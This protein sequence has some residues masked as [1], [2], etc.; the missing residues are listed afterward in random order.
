M[1][2]RPVPWN[3]LFLGL[4]GRLDMASLIFVEFTKKDADSLLFFC[5][6]Y[7]IPFGVFFV[8]TFILLLASI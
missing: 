3:A 1:L 6:T 2:D 4:R 8:D 7:S 5:L